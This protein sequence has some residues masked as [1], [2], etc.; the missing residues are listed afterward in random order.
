MV[1]LIILYPNDLSGR[2]CPASEKRMKHRIQHVIAVEICSVAKEQLFH[3]EF[4][5]LH[6][7]LFLCFNIL[8]VLGTTSRT[9]STGGSRQVLG[10][11]RTSD[12]TLACR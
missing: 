1:I 5:D 6:G 2:K 4:E 7:A 9:C 8:V 3:Q 11:E 12:E 10:M